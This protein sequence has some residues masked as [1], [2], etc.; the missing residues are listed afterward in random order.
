MQNAK[1][2]PIQNPEE[3]SKLRSSFPV[4]SGTH[5]RKEEPNEWTPVPVNEQPKKVFEDPAS[6]ADDVEVS[7]PCVKVVQLVRQWCMHILFKRAVGCCD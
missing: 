4:S 5:H 6:D 7:D 2:L 1:Q 3:K